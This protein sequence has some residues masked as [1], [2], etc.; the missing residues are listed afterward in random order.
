[1]KRMAHLLAAL[2]STVVLQFGLL[3]GFSQS[4]LFTGAETDY[5]AK[6]RHLRASLHLAAGRQ[7]HRLAI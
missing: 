2:A 1:M 7:R 6:P 5:H 4:Y 3:P